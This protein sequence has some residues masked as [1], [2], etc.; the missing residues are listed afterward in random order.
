MSVATEVDEPRASIFR[1]PDIRMESAIRLWQ[2]NASIY[3]RTYKMNLL[4]NFFEP[5]FYLVAMGVGLGRYLSSIHGVHYIDK[6][7]NA[8]RNSDKRNSLAKASARAESLTH[9]AARNQA[10][11]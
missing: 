11:N 8:K 1:T 9:Q 7:N 5:V 2:R 6:R 4:P 3:R 10:V